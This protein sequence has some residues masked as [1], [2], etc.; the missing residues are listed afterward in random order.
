[1][2]EKDK[3]RNQ[4]WDLLV[5]KGVSKSPHGR[6]PDFK[7]SFDAAKRLSRTVEWERA[8]VVFCSPD[9]AQRPVRRLVLEAGKDLIMPTP[10]IKDGYLLIG[11]DVPDAGAASTI[12]GAYRYGSPIREFPQVD[13]V[14]EGS[15]AVDLQGNRLGKG[16]GYG[17]REISELRSQGA[18]DD[19]TPLATTVD[20][21]QIISRVPVEEHDERINM[22]VTPLRVIRPLLDD[23]IPRVVERETEESSTAPESSQKHHKQK[24]YSTPDNSDQH[25]KTGNRRIRQ[26]RQLQEHLTDEKNQ[27]FKYSLVQ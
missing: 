20:E 6:I 4:I 9:S 7:D 22:I 15:V 19:D 8:G 26:H 12:R 27:Q 10:K 13:L 11:G 16:G 5:E 2:E 17:D 18:I 1:M 3:I 25:K 23:R 24:E 21:L 14:V